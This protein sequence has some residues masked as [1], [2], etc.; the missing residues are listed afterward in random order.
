M[1]SKNRTNELH[2]Q[3][4]ELERLVHEEMERQFQ[5]QKA[6]WDKEEVFYPISIFSYKN[7]QQG[8]SLCMKY[9][10]AELMI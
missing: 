8:L 4:A 2:T 1:N 5:R 3:E 10:I 6:Q 7:R 9:M